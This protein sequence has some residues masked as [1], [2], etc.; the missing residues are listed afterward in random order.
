M[1][2]IAIPMLQMSN[3]QRPAQV[4]IDGCIVWPVTYVE[5]PSLLPCAQAQ[6]CESLLLHFAPRLTSPVK[7]ALITSCVNNTLDSKQT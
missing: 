2:S 4:T 3:R 5:L 6:T 7:H 1:P